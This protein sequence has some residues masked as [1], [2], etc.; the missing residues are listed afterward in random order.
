MIDF[1]KLEDCDRTKIYEEYPHLDL[2]LSLDDLWLYMDQAFDRFLSSNQKP[3]G[4]CLSRFYS[5]PVWTLYGIFS[6]TH[7]ETV[8]HRKLIAKHVASLSPQTILDYGGGFGGLS[9][10]IA[11]LCPDSTVSVLEPYPS[12]SALTLSKELPNHYYTS[13]LPAHNVDVVLAID[14]FEHLVDPLLVL[15]RLSKS[16]RIGGHLIVANC[17]S[18]VIK[19]H[20]PSTFHLRYTFSFF[21]FLLGYKRVSSIYLTHAVIY[22]RSSRSAVPLILLRALS[23]LSRTLYSFRSFYTKRIKSWFS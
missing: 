9:R 10:S 11:H 18:P 8:K 5:H 22:Q 13:D 19:C 17:F 4:A 12:L 7:E 3:D 16:I 2:S 6:E 20:L 1:T 21:C 23:P 14:V 15:Y